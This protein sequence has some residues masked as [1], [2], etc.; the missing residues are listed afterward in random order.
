MMQLILPS[1][2]AYSWVVAHTIPPSP[3]SFCCTSSLCSAHATH[4]LLQQ[5]LLRRWCSSYRTPRESRLVAFRTAV[6]TLVLPFY[7]V[8]KDTKSCI[9]SFHFS[10]MH[11]QIL[12]NIIRSLLWLPLYAKFG[13]WNLTL[14]LGSLALRLE[15]SAASFFHTHSFL[16]EMSRI[17]RNCAQALLK[18]RQN[19]A[20]DICT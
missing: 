10:W 4:I 11:F 8:S 5:S 12:I 19:I 7:S 16:K 2:L 3:K 15:S 13:S 6:D 17:T 14:P 20:S 1:Q 9:H 18:G